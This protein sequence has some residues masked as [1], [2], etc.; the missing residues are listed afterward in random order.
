MMSQ[1]N[2]KYYSTIYAYYYVSTYIIN[3]DDHLYMK[4]E[5]GDAEWNITSM[6]V[7]SFRETEI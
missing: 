5:N 3:K 1:W 2:G 4:K 7:H 6:S